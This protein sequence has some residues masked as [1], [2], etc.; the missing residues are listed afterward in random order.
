MLQIAALAGCAPARVGVVCLAM[1]ATRSATLAGLAW[2]AVQLVVPVAR[3]DPSRRPPFSPRFSWSMFAGR[4]L[5]TCAHDLAWTNAT[6]ESLALPLPPATSPVYRV[7][8]ARTPDEFRRVVPLLTAYAD[9]DAVVLD[10]LNDVL[11]RHKRLVDPHGRYLLTSTLV[12]HTFD[13]DTLR[14]TL[15]LG[16]P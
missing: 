11:R 14:R 10:A 9:S 6:G 7:L 15:R 13:G 8:T 2:L 1:E 5:A 3:M 4:P 12:C 16:A